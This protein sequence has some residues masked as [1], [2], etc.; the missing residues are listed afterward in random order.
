MSIRT[1]KE[2]AA[3]QLARAAEVYGVTV[4]E[5]DEMDRRQELLEQAALKYAQ[6]CKPEAIALAFLLEQ[7]SEQRDTLVAVLTEVVSLLER[8]QPARVGPRLD[9]RS[10]AEVALAM[11]RTAL[12]GMPVP[13]EGESTATPGT[14]LAASER[15]QAAASAWHRNPV[16]E[17]KLAE[18]EG[19]A[20]DFARSCAWEPPSNDGSDNLAGGTDGGDHLHVPPLCTCDCHDHPAMMHIVPCCD[21]PGG[22]G[23]AGRVLTTKR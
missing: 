21:G 3:S 9:V 5:G 23:G 8:N 10:D 6:A 7:A 17:P 16:S 15:L 1:A 19:A 13:V 20:L 2:I 12:R 22:K 11:A 4:E 14:P 18:L